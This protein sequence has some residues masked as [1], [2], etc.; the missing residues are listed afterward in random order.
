MDRKVLG[1]LGAA[2]A[3]AIASGPAVAN[4]D[5]NLTPSQPLA[6]SIAPIAIAQETLASVDASPAAPE[7]AA[8]LAQFHHRR[9]RWVY[10]RHHHRHVAKKVSKSTTSVA[11]KAN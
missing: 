1:T 10:T 8:Q 11:L 4:V 6:A 7:H 2:F 3:L 9:D 5:A